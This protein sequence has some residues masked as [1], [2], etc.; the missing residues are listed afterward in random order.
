MEFGLHLFAVAGD[1]RLSLS[2]LNLPL[3]PSPECRG[4]GE[5]AR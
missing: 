4:T 2:H 5:G 1:G 3:T